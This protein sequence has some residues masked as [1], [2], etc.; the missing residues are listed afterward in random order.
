M[1]MHIPVHEWSGVT[2]VVDRLASAVNGSFFLSLIFTKRILYFSY[3]SFLFFL[4]AKFC[5]VFID[6]FLRDSFA[7][8]FDF[9]Q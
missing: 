9:N 2:W 3:I 8:S 1:R 4:L 5:S 7:F 6:I